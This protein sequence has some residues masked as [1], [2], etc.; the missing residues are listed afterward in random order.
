MQ[1]R[2]KVGE[3]AGCVRPDNGYITIG[4]DG[5]HYFAHRLAWFYEHGRWPEHHI[6]HINGVKAD[7]RIAN[8]RDVAAGVNLQNRRTPSSANKSSRLLGV[9]FCRRTGR[10]RSCIRVD[11]RQKSLGYFDTEDAAH[12]RYVE[13]KRQLHPGC[14]I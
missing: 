10:W 14:T 1:C 8:L 3:I 12:A 7:N 9:S 11:G 2:V 6:D 13:V 4:I 5:R